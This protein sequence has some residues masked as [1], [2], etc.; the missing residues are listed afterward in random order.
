MKKMKKQLVNWHR[1]L[2][3]IIWL[4]HSSFWYLGQ[5]GCWLMDD[6]IS[7]DLKMEFIYSIIISIIAI[8]FAFTF[9]VNIFIDNGAIKKI[10]FFETII[11]AVIIIF[12]WILINYNSIIHLNLILANDT[13]RAWCLLLG[14]LSNWS[15]AALFVLCGSTLRSNKLAFVSMGKIMA[16]IYGG[17][18]MLYTIID[19][20][21]LYELNRYRF[22]N[23]T[24]IQVLWGPLAVSLVSATAFF[25]FFTVEN[26]NNAIEAKEQMLK[27]EKGTEEVSAMKYCSHCGKEIMSEA[28]ICP[29]CGCP[30]ENYKTVQ[31]QDAPSTG[32]N[33][34]SFLIPLAGLII[35]LMDKDRMPQRARAAG[36]WALIGVGVSVGLVVLYT[37]L[38][39][40]FVASLY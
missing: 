30:T 12:R 31:E 22:T 40:V 34:L 18:S 35:Y 11:W 1:W 26:K 10:A 36:K 29:H 33:V 19:F 15:N 7:P 27:N 28:V 38:G 5:W 3:P 9:L 37:I 24:Y 8:I 14:L 16:T 13:R 25:V 21:L 39:V 17:I 4:T 2:L 32:L 6:K 23:A 20:N